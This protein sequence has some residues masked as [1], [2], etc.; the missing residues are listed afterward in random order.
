MPSNAR[1]LCVLIVQL[2]AVLLHQCM[3]ARQVWLGDSEEEDWCPICLH[4]GLVVA[5]LLVD[6]LVEESLVDDGERLRD[7]PSAML[8]FPQKVVVA[9][10]LA[11]RS[12]PD[13]GALCKGPQNETVNVLGETLQGE[14]FFYHL[15]I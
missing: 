2:E 15:Q 1:T 3:L 14:L 13:M 7:I 9:K 11:L 10:Q 5:P 6:L 8:Q 12:V 4:E